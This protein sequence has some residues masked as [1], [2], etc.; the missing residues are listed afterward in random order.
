MP[1]PAN[2]SAC[3]QPHKRRTKILRGRVAGRCGG[4]Q[5]HI[6][7]GYGKVA[8][9]RRFAQHALGPIS[10]DSVSKTLRCSEGDPTRI[11]FAHSITYNHSHQGMVIAPSP[12]IDTL[13]IRPG[14]NGLHAQARCKLDGEALAALGTTASEHSAAALGGHTGAETVGLGTLA[15]I[16]LVRTLHDFYP[17]ACLNKQISRVSFKIVGKTA[18]ECQ[19][20]GRT[21][22]QVT[23]CRSNRLAP[24]RSENYS[25]QIISMSFRQVIKLC[26]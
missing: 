26:G 23:T 14:F 9:A 16:R 6:M 20:A 7:P 2:A 18:Q 1:L 21:C 15:L 25:F 10:Q 19:Q 11:A 17:P 13:E 8:R 24:P 4:E 12:C 22:L 3:R 5:D